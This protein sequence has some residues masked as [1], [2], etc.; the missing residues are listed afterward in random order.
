M[1]R[2]DVP[3]YTCDRCK[4]VEEI[5]RPEQEYRWGGINYSE[6]NGP[7]WVGTHR[8]DKP[9]WADIC[10]GCLTELHTWWLNT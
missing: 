7:R 5:R 4:S 3:I 9:K 2:I 10:P 6:V 8:S 1:A